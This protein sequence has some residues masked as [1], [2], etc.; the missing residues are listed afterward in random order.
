MNAFATGRINAP[1]TSSLHWPDSP[2]DAGGG[3]FVPGNPRPPTEI[4]F[5]P[6]GHRDQRLE[7]RGSGAH[8][9]IQAGIH[10]SPEAGRGLQ[11]PMINRSAQ[12]R[13]RRRV[14][15]SGPDQ[16]VQPDLDLGVAIQSRRDIRVSARAVGTERIGHKG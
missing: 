9:F 16:E 4:T 10:A 3:Q 8:Q 2:S 6:F 15:I 12:P 5:G 11:T 13:L 7:A 14:T 1:S